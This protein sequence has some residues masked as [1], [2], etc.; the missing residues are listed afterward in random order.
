METANEIRQI[1][2]DNHE[3]WFLSHCYPNIAL[4]FLECDGEWDQSKADPE[5]LKG[6]KSHSHR[7]NYY[8]ACFSENEELPTWI[9]P[10]KIDGKIPGFML[11]RPCDDEEFDYEIYF[12]YVR[13]EFRNRGVLRSMLSE[14][15]SNSRITLESSGSN[16]DEVWQ[17]CGFDVYGTRR[18][19]S[20]N[21]M[22]N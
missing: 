15:P 10:K 21:L 2:E 6:G 13:K 16:T 7:Y 20:N 4:S 17:K 11:L 14:I 18:G 12:A 3:K 8:V 19:S 9:I 1:C 22:K 5:K